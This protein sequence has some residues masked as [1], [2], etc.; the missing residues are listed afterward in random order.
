MDCSPSLAARSRAC[1]A[2]LA[3]LWI[4]AG[5]VPVAAMTLDD[6]EARA[7]AL[8]R[9]PYRPGACGQI[10]E[11]LKE[12]HY[13]EWRQIRFRPTA[14]LWRNRMLTFQAQF[15][16]PGMLYQNTVRIN[17]VDAAGVHPLEFSPEQFEYGRSGIASRV[18]QDLGYAG[19]RL[20][21]PLKRT[22]VLD[23]VIVFLGASYFRAL[24]RDEVFGLSARGLAIDTAEPS[25]EEF[26]YFCEF[27]LVRPAPRARSMTVFALLDSERVTGAYRFAIQ[28]GAQTRVNVEA[29]LI[30]RKPVTKLGIAPLTSM[31]F[32]GE[33]SEVSRLDYRPEVHDSDGL[34]ANFAD[35]GEWLWRPIDNPRRL[36][37][38]ALRT[39]KLG[40]FGLMQ[41]DRVFDHYQDIEARSELRPSAWVSPRGDWGAGRVE[42]VEIPTPNDSNDNIVAYWVPEKTP[43]PGERLALAY[44]LFWHGVEPERSP[45]AIVGATRRDRGTREGAHRFV[46]DFVGGKLAALPDVAVVR[47]LIT[48]GNQPGEAELLEQQVYRNPVTG[49]W[50]LV[51]QVRPLGNEPIELRAFLKRKDEVL[52]ETWSASIEP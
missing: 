26:P 1:A 3:V 42:L 8:A 40:G 36:R 29:R 24:G 22:D 30:P 32:H 2:G 5:S 52:T 37:V 4:L 39:G 7:Q 14:S 17:E 10:P 50:R 44:D 23:E 21:Y 18:P 15:F 41:R 19:F 43:A 46:I 34:L 47:G 33:N 35:T 25:G 28:P 11:W 6:V 45:N 49:G 9:K 20:H 27:W 31:F 12:I 38:R 51:F 13:D 16:H 48:A